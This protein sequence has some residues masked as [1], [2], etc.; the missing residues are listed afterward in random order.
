MRVRQN[1]V[2]NQQRYHINT[3]GEKKFIVL[4]VYNAK[5]ATANFEKADPFW[6]SEAV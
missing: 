6:D 3:V 1:V 4:N 5:T 2:Q